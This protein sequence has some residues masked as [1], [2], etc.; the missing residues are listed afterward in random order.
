MSGSLIPFIR[1]IA[2]FDK[3]ELLKIGT[4]KI[5]YK[6]RKKEVYEVLGIDNKF[7]NN[8]L[9]FDKLVDNF[10]M[11]ITNI[12]IDDYINN[13]SDLKKLYYYL[14]KHYPWSFNYKNKMLLSGDFLNAPIKKEAILQ[15]NKIVYLDG[16]ISLKD[17]LIEFDDQTVVNIKPS[18]NITLLNSTII[19]KNN[20]IAIGNTQNTIAIKGDS[21]SS[22]L[23]TSG[24][25]IKLHFVRFSGFGNQINRRQKNRDVTGGITFSE[26]IVEIKNCIFRKNYLGDDFINFYRCKLMLNIVKVTSALYDAI[27]IDYCTGT[28]NNLSVIGAGNDGIDFAGSKINLLNSKFI[29][30][31]ESSSR[32]LSILESSRLSVSFGFEESKNPNAIVTRTFRL[33]KLSSC[34]KIES[35]TTARVIHGEMIIK[36]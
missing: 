10:F 25:N 36:R 11:E 30:F 33:S 26:N 34:R 27:D 21:L 18:T 17:T 14:Q 23:F 32:F 1:E 24:G 5:D 8:N 9:I 13:N 3:I 20:V 22:L 7:L 12:Q 19:F 2:V 15:K 31:R 28:I 4:K 29:Y 35:L 6:K 16:N